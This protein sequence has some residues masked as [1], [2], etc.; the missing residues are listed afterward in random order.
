MI[1]DTET[2]RPTA[3]FL[4]ITDADAGASGNSGGVANRFAFREIKGAGGIIKEA[5][6][7]AAVDLQCLTQ[8]PWAAG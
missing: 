6:I 8:F 5:C 7:E 4:G 2:Q 1:A 3:C